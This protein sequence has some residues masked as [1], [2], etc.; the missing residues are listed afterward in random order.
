MLYNA[1]TTYRANHFVVLDRAREEINKKVR[2]LKTLK[3]Q[4]MKELDSI[5]ETRK[6]LLKNHERLSSWL[7]DLKKHQ[8]VLAER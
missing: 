8:E 4:Q 5:T 3:E 6:L 2:T 1:T 7:D